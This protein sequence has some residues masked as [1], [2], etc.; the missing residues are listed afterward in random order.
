VAVLRVVTTLR[1]V[2][3]YHN[4]LGQP[5]GA[6]LPAW[7]GAREPSGDT[8]VGRYCRVERL[9]A[10][11]HAASLFEANRTDA[12][13]RSWTYLP[14]GPYERLTEYEAWV[15]H[16]EAMPDPMFFAIVDTGTE[17]A[18]GVASYLRISRDAG[19]IEVGHINYSPLLRRSRAGT[20][21]MF[22]MMRHAFEDLGNRRYEWKC[23]ALNSA[24]L[25]AAERLGFV[26]EGVF[27][28]S[29]VVK[30]HSRDTAWFSITDDEWP[31]VRDAFRR[32]LDPANFDDEGVQRTALTARASS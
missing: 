32:W 30:G 13:G 12:S 23:N 20:E 17:R 10:G 8:K 16:L 29:S 15:R 18:V 1:R 22:V 4:D 19:S 3:R 27:R 11:R 2:H 28:N 6:P 7:R 24:S 26:F 14:Y 9:D 31:R 21:A 25:Q 5:V